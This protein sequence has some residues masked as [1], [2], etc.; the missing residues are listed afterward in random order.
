MVYVFT[1]EVQPFLE[2]VSLATTSSQPPETIAG[3]LKRVTIRIRSDIQLG[4]FQGV[5]AVAGRSQFYEIVATNDGPSQAYN[6]SLT[7]VSPYPIS[8]WTVQMGGTC[9]LGAD[10]RTLTCSIGDLPADSQTPNRGVA[11]SVLYSVPRN[12]TPTVAAEF[13]APS[14]RARIV[15]HFLT[16]R[17]ETV[18]PQ[19]ITRQ[20]GID[21]LQLSSLVVNA[22]CSITQSV[23]TLSNNGPSDCSRFEF[24]F[25]TVNNL[26]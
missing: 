20:D 23:F 14:A 17:S 19:P 6:V 18:S 16:A 22:N 21:V 9:V 11:V 15:R 8:S 4:R 26:T 1:T 10:N 5:L 25:Q 7:T 2:I 3:S 12:E 24:T 13:E